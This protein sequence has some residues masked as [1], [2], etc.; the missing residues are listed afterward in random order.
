MVEA[1]SV[2][3]FATEFP[4]YKPGRRGVIPGWLTTWGYSW[5]GDHLG[6]ELDGWPPGVIAGWETTW[7]YSWMGDHLGLE[8]DGW[9]SGV[10]AEWVTTWGYTWMGD[11]LGVIAGWVTM[12]INLVLI[13]KTWNLCVWSCCS[14]SLRCFEGFFS[15]FSGFPPSVKST[16]RSNL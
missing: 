13:L 14:W 15:G 7:G 9:P 4:N 8:L 1:V 10:I 5:M 11:H 16:P 6:L 2:L 3:P 12:G